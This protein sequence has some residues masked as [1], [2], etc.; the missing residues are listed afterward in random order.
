[1]MSRHADL[2]PGPSRRDQTP[3]DNH[4]GRLRLCQYKGLYLEEFPDMLA[5]SLISDDCTPA[6]DLDAYMQSCGRL[7][8]PKTFKAAKHLLTMGLSDADKECH[9]KSSMVSVISLAKKGNQI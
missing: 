4:Q 6:P 7:V 8:D 2:E 1:M 9:L 5:G 3:T